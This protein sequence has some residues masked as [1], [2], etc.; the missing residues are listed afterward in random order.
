MTNDVDT[1]APEIMNLIGKHEK[2]NV[3]LDRES[4]AVPL[5]F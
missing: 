4:N 1:L 2:E 3:C 5:E